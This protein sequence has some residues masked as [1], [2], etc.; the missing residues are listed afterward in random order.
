MSYLIFNKN[1]NNVLNTLY[2]IAENESDLNNLNI[3]KNEYKIIETDQTNF[4]LIK[5]MQKVA[6]NYNENDQINFE[7]CNFNF[8]NKEELNKYINN[9]KTI[10]KQFFL[11]SPNHSLK[12]KWDNYLN[13]LESLN[14]TDITYPLNKSLE[15]YFEELN[16]TSLNPLQIP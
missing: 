14:T 10:I 11:H 1:S 8:Q 5:N 12:N 3:E 4:N 15:Q 2:K 7:E 16:Q 9:F 13:Q 6:I